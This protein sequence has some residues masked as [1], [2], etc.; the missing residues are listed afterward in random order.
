M[1]IQKRFIRMAAICCL[2]SV[3]TTLGIHAFFPDPPSSFEERLFM[4][5]DPIYILNRWWV[6]V[7]CLLVLVAMWGFAQLEFK[8]SPGSVGLGFLFL[9][10]FAIAEITRQMI[11]LFYMNGLREQ[12]VSATDP[13][14]K[15]GIKITLTH[16]GLLTAPLFGLFIMAFGLGGICYGLSLVPSKGFT[17]IISLLLLI[18][19]FA[20]LLFLGNSFWRSSGLEMFIEKFNLV[21]T[22][23]MRLVIGIWMLKRAAQLNP[24]PEAN[25]RKYLAGKTGRREDRFSS[26]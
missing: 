10:V 19:G 2:L 1:I 15:E 24:Y 21:F 23:A 26:F 5:R 7:H 18:S 20:S 3:I 16:A 8:N 11:V 12:Y 14:L 9:A 22:P 13:V 17:G 25:E 6:I 4:F